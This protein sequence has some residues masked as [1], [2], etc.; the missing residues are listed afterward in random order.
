M[1]CRIF[2]KRQPTT[3]NAN[4][5]P[6]KPMKN[7]TTKRFKSEFLACLCASR[8]TNCGSTSLLLAFSLC[9]TNRR[10]V[11][12]ATSPLLSQLIQKCCLADV[13]NPNKHKFHARMRL[14]SWDRKYRTILRQDQINIL[15][16]GITFSPLKDGPV[17]RENDLIL[18][19]ETQVLLLKNRPLGLSYKPLYKSGNVHQR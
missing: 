1:L 6:L 2:Y 19:L 3:K 18:P 12:I 10:R 8:L 7:T 5:E 16:P 17:H 15:F 4:K 11:L 14:R 9:P 13:C